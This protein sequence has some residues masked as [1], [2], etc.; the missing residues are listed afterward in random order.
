MFPDIP[1]E[2]EILTEMEE[3]FLAP[4]ISFMS[5]RATVSDQQYL[6]KGRVVNI[7]TDVPTSVNILPRAFSDTL[8]IPI[9]FRRKKSYKTNIDFENVRPKAI[10]EAAAFLLQ[11]PL[12]Q[13]FK[14][15]ID[16]DRLNNPSYFKV[17]SS[18]KPENK[19][20]LDD[21]AEDD[22][23]DGE[24]TIN[25]ANDVTLLTTAIVFAPGE[26]RRPESLFAQYIEAQCFV[27]IY[28]GELKQKPTGMTLQNWIKSR[29]MRDDR[30]YATIAKLFF[31]ALKLRTEKVTSSISF[32]LRKAKS[33]QKFKV[34][35]VVDGNQ[36]N[37]L[38]LQ[39]SGYRVF[40][41]D[42]GSPSFWEKKKKELFA[43]MQQ[44]GT[45]TIFVT[46]SPAETRWPEL[47]VI[48][49]KVV[50]GDTVNM[51]AAKSMKN[52]EK[53]RLVKT[54]P[55]TAARYLEYQTRQLFCLLK[56]SNSVF[57]EHNLLDYYI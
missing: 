37:E 38:I 30:R 9:C 3:R 21:N 8:V 26:G 1:R 17:P 32:C 31:S 47:I 5:I 35:D 28:C 43:M 50:D 36:L 18:H 29:I 52:Q 57:Q 24:E 39:D 48:L 45:P 54:D 11:S 25:V 14:I 10:A 51:D 53:V 6:V 4:R 15:V 55:V 2:L 46:L 16:I 33:K 27:K 41:V 23:V 34:R 13:H 19:M 49:K 22:E 20:E 42:R 56:Q 12:Y 40:E 44:I 7:P